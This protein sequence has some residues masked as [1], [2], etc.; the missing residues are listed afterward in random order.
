MSFFLNLSTRSKLLCSFMIVIAINLIIAMTTILSL[1]NVRNTAIKIEEVLNIAFNRILTTQVAVEDFSSKFSMGLNE[2]EPTYSVQSL[3]SEGDSIIRRARQ[4]ADA[5]KP[6]FL[7]TDEYR[8]ACLNLKSFIYKASDITDSQV[9]P[10]A[11]NGKIEEAYDIYM[12]EV[13]PLVME[14]VKTGSD[15]FHL[16]ND[17]CIALT[18]EASEPTPMIVASV[19]T[20]IGVIMALALALGMSNYMSLSLK[21]QMYILEKLKSGDFSISIKDSHKDEFGQS[22]EM[23]RDLRNTLSRIIQMTQDESHHLKSEMSHLQDI[24]STI[25]RV[26]SDIQNQAIT[27]AAASDEMVSTTTDIARNCESAASGSELCKNITNNG[28]NMV[29]QAAA[30]IR[31][32]SEHTRDNATK[33]ENLARQS[34]DIGSIVSTIDDIAAQTNLLALNAAIEAARAGEAGRGFAVVADEV[35]ALASRTSQSTQ[36]ISRMIKNIQTEAAVATDSI[37]ASVSN[38]D[39]VAEDAQQIMQILKD[40]TENVNGVNTQITQI[41]TAAEEQTAATAEISSH[42]QSVTSV[43][44]DMSADADKQYA[45]MGKA[46]EDLDDLLKALSYFKTR[47]PKAS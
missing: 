45:A 12:T 24:S 38:M 29:A 11:R 43:A 28:M 6:D 46:T 18:N 1:N 14:A 44:A 37:N 21:G 8:Q 34:R 13:D 41:A 35:R 4:V 40:I 5:V 9:M 25:A 3:M 32:Q 2:H 39:T 19:F 10:L 23:I 42:M 7:G 15:I 27:V 20:V 47:P 22:H 31:Q 16:Q 30:N 36:E 33:I 17:Y 26:S